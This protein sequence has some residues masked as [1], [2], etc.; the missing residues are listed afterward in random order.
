MRSTICLTLAALLLLSAGCTGLR[1]KEKQ[2]VAPV[3]PEAKI[4]REDLDELLRFSGEFARLPVE[5]RVSECDR[6]VQMY[7]A[8]QT[9]G[10]RLHLFVAQLL[11]ERCGDVRETSSVLKVRQS[12]IRDERVRSFLAL[13]MQVLARLDSEIEQK[14]ALDLNLKFSQQQARKRKRELITFESEAKNCESELAS[15][16]SVLE[17]RTGELK[18]LQDKLDALK[19]IEQNLGGAQGR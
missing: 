15:C 1:K 13:Q 8:N 17:T 7:S 11:T 16:E 5:Q 12:E 6:I 9:M 3:S 18:A 10:L 19:S 2:P 14:R 4:A